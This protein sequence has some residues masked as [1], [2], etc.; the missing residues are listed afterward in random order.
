[1]Q[2]TCRPTVYT[3]L[4]LKAYRPT[5]D[6]RMPILKMTVGLTLLSKPQA[7]DCMVKMTILANHIGLPEKFMYSI[8][9]LW[10]YAYP[11]IPANI[12][13]N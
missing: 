3:S 4:L 1:M 13:Q 12:D 9:L 6:L 11:S 7:S 8:R 10:E 5:C 2:S